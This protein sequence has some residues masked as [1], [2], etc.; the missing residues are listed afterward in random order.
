[1]RGL[2]A[3]IGRLGRVG[4]GREAARRG[5][6]RGGSPA[7]AKQR[8]GNKGRG[9]GGRLTG[10]AGVSVGEEKKDKGWRG[11]GPLRGREGGLLGR[12]AER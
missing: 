7:R 9:R 3:L 4:R 6:D 5:E 10:G 1:M 8:R 12:W 2:T 11:S